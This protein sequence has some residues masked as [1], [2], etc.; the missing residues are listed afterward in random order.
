MCLGCKS[1]VITKGFR[2]ET[3]ENTK[4][5]S[6]GDGGCENHKEMGPEWS[7]D[8][9]LSPS[10]GHGIIL[11]FISGNNSKDDIRPPDPNP[12]ETT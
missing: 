2:F 11:R 6:E 7:V 8:L 4:S 5:Q 1:N 10:E 12:T 3:N 9:T